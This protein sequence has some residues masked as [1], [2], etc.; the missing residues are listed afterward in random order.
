[1]T[2]RHHTA[3]FGIVIAVA[4]AVAFAAFGALEGLFKGRS[5]PSLGQYIASFACFGFLLGSILAFDPSPEMRSPDRPLLRTALGA[6]AG[7]C[8]GLVW[9]WSTEAV[10]LSALV[11]GGLGYAGM[12]WAKYV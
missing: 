12:T 1:M 11:A 3:T 10:A 6:L 7:L 5:S 9:S 8:L 4:S 2:K